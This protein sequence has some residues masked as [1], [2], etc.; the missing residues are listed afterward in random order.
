[1]RSQEEAPIKENAMFR[2]ARSSVQ[3]CGSSGDSLI[4]VGSEC[5]VI[6]YNFPRNDYGECDGKDRRSC[7]AHKRRAVVWRS[8]AGPP[9]KIS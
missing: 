8:K 2:L 3:P 9:R 6:K 5:G 4:Q 1:M 7:L